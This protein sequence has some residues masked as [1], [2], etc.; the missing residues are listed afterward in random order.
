MKQLKKK[1]QMLSHLNIP[2]MHSKIPTISANS[3]AS[4][5]YNGSDGF[6]MLPNTLDT[7]RDVN[8]TGPI[9]S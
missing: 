3:M 8:A 5:V 1:E 6:T 7:R 4:S 9:A 2:I